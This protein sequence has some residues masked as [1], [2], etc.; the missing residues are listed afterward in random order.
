MNC[1]EFICKS[2]LKVQYIGLRYKCYQYVTTLT[3][4]WPPCTVLPLSS[5]VLGP[6]FLFPLVPPPPVFLLTDFLGPGQAWIRYAWHSSALCFTSLHCT[7][8]WNSLY[9]NTL[10]MQWYLVYQLRETAPVLTSDIGSKTVLVLAHSFWLPE[11]ANS[12]I[13][14][15]TDPLRYSRS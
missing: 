15:S 11:R 3:N 13:R 2:D 8:C 6:S 4:I 7:L 12:G 14:L 10:Y 9:C 1:Q 5:P